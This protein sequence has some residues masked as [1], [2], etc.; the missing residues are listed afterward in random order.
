MTDTA[1]LALFTNDA[2][3]DKAFEALRGSVN[4]TMIG[5]ATLVPPDTSTNLSPF[6]PFIVFSGNGLGVSQFMNHGAASVTAL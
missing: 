1:M 4:I 6:V 3:R 2:K 5:N